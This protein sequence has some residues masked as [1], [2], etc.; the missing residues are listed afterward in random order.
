MWPNQSRNGSGAVITKTAYS[1]QIPVYITIFPQK[2]ILTQEE[3]VGILRQPFGEIPRWN[4]D[5]ATNLT[6]HIVIK[7]KTQ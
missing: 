3:S 7:E 1:T 5:R 6:F 2:S 4:D